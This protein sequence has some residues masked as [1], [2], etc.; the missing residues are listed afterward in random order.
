MNWKLFANEA[1]SVTIRKTWEK[2]GTHFAIF[3]VSGFESR[4]IV[5]LCRAICEDPAFEMPES[6]YCGYAAYQGNP[7]AGLGYEIN[8]SVHGGMTLS[9]DIGEWHVFGFDCAHAR[10]HFDPCCRDLDWLTA[11]CERMA[12]SIDQLAAMEADNV[13]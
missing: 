10:D 3:Q 5:S 4:A 2:D 6:W 9:E 7:L 1:E 12:A 8:V 13:D 11:E